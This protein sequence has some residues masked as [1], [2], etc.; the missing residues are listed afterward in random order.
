MAS[1]GWVLVFDLDETLSAVNDSEW[2]GKLPPFKKA[3]LNRKAIEILKRAIALR[4]HGQVAAIL[5][6]TNNDSD[7]YIDGIVKRLEAACGCGSGSSGKPLF[8]LKAKRN[9]TVT[10]RTPDPVNGAGY[11]LKDVVTVERMMTRLGKSTDQLASR[12]FFFDDIPNHV[13]SKE[14]QPSQYIVMKWVQKV[15]GK[16]VSVH[17]QTNYTPVYEALGYPTVQ[18]RSGTP[19]PRRGVTKKKHRAASRS[20]DLK[21]RRERDRKYKN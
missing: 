17:D 4:R 6:L 7:E 15:D 12:I 19:Y 14:V 21:R 9:D 11:P 2:I 1:P 16:I 8:D 13:M 10:P 5:L 18:K 3:I 20:R